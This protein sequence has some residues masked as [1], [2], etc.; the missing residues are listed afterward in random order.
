V[1]TVLST[2]R[3]E[4]T[5]GRPAV[6]QI[7][8]T[9]TDDI[10]DGVTVSIDGL[11][12]GWVGLDQPVVRLFPDATG[13]LT[14]RLDLPRTYPAGTWTFTVRVVSTI[15]ADRHEIHELPVEIAPVESLTLEMRPSLV[16]A[17]KEADF[18]AFVTNTGNTT[19]PVEV[20]ATDPTRET[21]CTT[22]PA[23]V[24]I[25]PGEVGH[26]VITARAK[27]P[28][29][30]GITMRN[31]QVSAISPGLQIDEAAR[32]DQKPRIARGLITTLILTA[33]ILLWAT[34]FMLVG[35]LIGRQPAVEKAVPE[36]FNKGGVREVSL[37][38]VGASVDG[39]VLASTTG[40]GI[41]RITVEA[42]RVVPVRPDDPPDPTLLPE[43]RLSGS[44]AT[45][46]DGTYQ[47]SALLPGD[48][49]IKFSAEGF[50]SVW[51]PDTAEWESAEIVKLRP[52]EPFPL[53][54]VVLVG[55]EGTLV[56]SIPAPPGG[57]PATVT[58]QQVP[59]AGQPAPDPL[60]PVT[61]GPEGNLTVPGLPTPA[62]FD[63][64]IERTGFETQTVRVDVAPG[65]TSVLDTV[66]LSAAAGSIAGFVVDENG[67]RIG[68][69][70]V[71]IE[72]GEE[73]IVI[74]TPT[75]GDIGT[76]RV[77]GLITPRTYVLTFSK[78]GYTS[79]TEA[80]PLGP[81]AS[82]TNATAQL[83]GGLGSMEGLVITGDSQPLGGVTVTARRGDFVATT[84]TLTAG[85]GPSGVG[86]FAIADLP[87][88]GVYTVTFELEG[89]VSETVQVEF[90][91][92]GL[93]P[94]VNA[95]M[96]PLNGRILGNV[97]VTGIGQ[98]G[99]DVVL[100]DGLTERTT[101][102]A[103][104]P[105]G[106]YGFADVP[107]GSYTLTFSGTGVVTRR[108]LVEVLPGQG[109]PVDVELTR[110]L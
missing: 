82:I 34:I 22:A 89:Y 99:I 27:R 83:I 45:A 49:R 4:I 60:P 70:S 8:V 57:G 46:E 109:L 20:I 52:T 5:P 19:L 28:W 61:V 44:A 7:E 76:F 3:L 77:D 30:G 14:V 25:A 106:G 17:G 105:P 73:P 87:T 110:P 95:T 12:P 38:D 98:G 1:R 42:Y 97:R 81:G 56:G 75:A 10:I 69:V 47:L 67:T 55:Q 31:L 48:Y 78:E 65:S 41:E 91:G 103:S 96:S 80:L 102:T 53:D 18:G 64:R 72:G 15:D 88:P 39:I 108:V 37:L 85:D 9:N 104:D 93:R 2:P 100:T 23:E 58:L 33:I 11:D 92:A 90:V 32:F 59:P 40:E 43:G 29:F 62:T 79:V 84:A 107:P 6:F 24:L 94:G 74:T 13:T 68:G 35:G 16:K 86:T 36:N 63:V 21:T 66:Q 101:K 51:Y 50:D 54:D 71:R 26:M